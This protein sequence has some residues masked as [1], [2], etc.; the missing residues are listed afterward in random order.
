MS[1]HMSMSSV[2]ISITESVYIRLSRRKE[3]DE[4]F[5]AVLDRMLGEK[6]IRRCYGIL[7]GDKETIRAMKEELRLS[8]SAKWRDIR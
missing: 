7:K 3:K 8:R 2:N 6:D 1:T 4:S 5:S